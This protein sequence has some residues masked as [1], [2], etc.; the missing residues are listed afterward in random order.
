MSDYNNTGMLTPEQAQAQSQNRSNLNGRLNQQKYQY[1]IGA[2]PNPG[3][4]TKSKIQT[5]W[6]IN[7]AFILILIAGIGGSFV[8]RFDMDKF[9]SFLEVFAYVWA[10]LVVSYGG[11]KAIKN[12][13][14]KKY[15]PASGQTIQTDDLPPQ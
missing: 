14:E 1:E 4:E 15:T 12:W 6:I 3:V 11:G 10:P 5:K 13:T 2:D 9:V 8:E 7:V